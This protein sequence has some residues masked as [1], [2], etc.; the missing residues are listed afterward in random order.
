MW[1]I[2]Y[3]NL[4]H[5][6]LWNVI[7]SANKQKRNVQLF[8]TC[9]CVLC[10]STRNLKQPRDR[11]S[12]NSLKRPGET[13]ERYC[14]FF[15][16]YMCNIKVG[17][18]E[19]MYCCTKCSQLEYNTVFKNIKYLSSGGGG[20][21]SKFLITSN[22]INPGPLFWQHLNMTAFCVNEHPHDF[23]VTVATAIF[24]GSVL[25]ISV[26]NVAQVWSACSHINRWAPG[27]LSKTK[28]KL[29]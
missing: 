24:T 7:F 23:S 14:S 2:I 12:W 18:T 13:R 10:V 8:L 27:L 22:Y 25:A 16:F 6:V 20:Q 19:L 4:L 28:K 11:S 21:H 29:I 1:S 5:H 9:Y 15:V 17:Y 26:L 3:L